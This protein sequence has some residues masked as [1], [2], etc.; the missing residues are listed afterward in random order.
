[1]KKLAETV[2]ATALVVGLGAYVWAQDSSGASQSPSTPYVAPYSYG[3]WG[4]GN[5]AG[6]MMGMGQRGM[7]GRGMMGRSAMGGG[8]MGGGMMY[9]SMMG[10]GRSGWGGHGMMGGPMWMNPSLMAQDGHGFC[11]WSAAEF[12]R[13]AQQNNIST[14]LTKESAKKWAQYYLTTYNN[15]DL[16]IGKIQDR[17]DAFEVEIRSKKDNKVLDRILID[18]QTGWVSRAR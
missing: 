10:P 13:W 3:C 6:P 8:M 18:K 9:G 1:M 11:G 14:P 7:M 17:G 16:K 15:P 12:S 5:A 4:S 2:L